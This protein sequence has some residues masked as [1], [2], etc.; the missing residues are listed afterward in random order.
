MNVVVFGSGTGTNLEALLRDQ[1]KP[2]L[3]YRV[4]AVFAD[5][6]CR[7]LEIGKR[8][9]LPVIYHPFSQFMKERGSTDPH[10]RAV[11]YAYDEKS[12]RLLDAC[13]AK[14]GFSIQCVVLAGYMRIVYSPLLKRYRS[15][16]LNVH[17][18]DLTRLDAQG[19]RCYVGSDVVYKALIHGET[20]TRSS[21]IS[22]EEGI[23]TGPLFVLGPW[24]PYEEGYPVT[25][26]RANRHQEK[27]K[28]L[29]DWPALTEAVRRLALGDNTSCAEYLELSRTDR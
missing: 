18:A 5:R 8:E 19:K 13:A 25:R 1:I 28:K 2:P 21:V 11:R 9:S 14:H 20:R 16:I 7:I 12:A 6:E 15:R 4:R 26:E 22:V 3:L 23:D 27:Q 29:S 10:D 17:P 24:V